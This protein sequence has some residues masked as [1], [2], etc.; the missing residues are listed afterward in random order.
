MAEGEG[1]GEGSDVG[2]GGGDGVDGGEGSLVAEGREVEDGCKVEGAA[3]STVFTT[4]R[5][6]AASEPSP[7]PVARRRNARRSNVRFFSI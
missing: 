2:E 1:V 5:Q 4:L 6:A 3:S 7:T